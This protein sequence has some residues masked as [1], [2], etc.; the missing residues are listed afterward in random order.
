MS[1]PP[2]IRT[3]ADLIA[4]LEVGHQ[5]DRERDALGWV[6]LCTDDESGNHVHTSGLFDTP[7]AALIHAGER[8]A[9]DVRINPE[10]EPLW[11]YTVLPMFK[12]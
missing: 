12:P 7:E 1:P 4:E 8:H 5:R 10:T 2:I 3:P 6:V 11:T 9:E